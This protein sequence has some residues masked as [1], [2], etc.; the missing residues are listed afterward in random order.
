MAFR[1]DS[2]PAV[3][4]SLADVNYLVLEVLPRLSSGTI[5]HFHDIYLPY[6]YQRDLLDTP[7]HWAE[8][9]LTRAYLTH[10]HRARILACLSHLHYARPADLGKVFPDYVP[11]QGQDGLR[12]HRTAPGHFPS[13]LWFT[14]C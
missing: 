12:P 3:R 5:V 8:T 14:V 10:N 6:D 4:S 13:S 1:F 9:S 11:Q 2:V 7:F